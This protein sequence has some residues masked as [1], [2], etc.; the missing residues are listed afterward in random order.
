VCVTDEVARR[1]STYWACVRAVSEDVAKLPIVVARRLERGREILNGNR[2]HQLLNVQPNKYTTAI[3][4]RETMMAWVL[5]HGN[6]IA[7]IEWDGAGRPVALHVIP[8]PCVTP[9]IRK[10]DL[11]YDVQTPRGPVVTLEAD[12][13]FHL[14]GLG[15][16]SIWG[17]S[18]LKMARET[19]S[20]AT[21]ANRFA[22]SMF[23]KGVKASG[24]L[25]HPGKLSPTAAKNIRESFHERYAGTENAHKTI[26]LEEGMTWTPTSIT[27]EDAQMLETRQYDV[28][29]ICRWFRVAPHKVQHLA[30]ATY[31]NIEHQGQEYVGDSLHAWMTRWEQEG[32]IKLIGASSSTYMRHNASALVRGDYKSRMEGHNIARTGG[33]ASADDIR[34]LEDMNPLPDD[35]GQIY[36]VPAGVQSARAL[37]ATPAPDP[38]DPAAPVVPQPAADD[39]IDPAEERALVSLVSLALAPLLSVEVDKLSRSI[40]RGDVSAWSEKFHSDDRVARMLVPMSIAGEAVSAAIGAEPDLE[41]VRAWCS[42]SVRYAGAAA[43]S[44]DPAAVCA[45][46][47]KETRAAGLALSFIESVRAAARAKKEIGHAS[48]A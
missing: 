23:E 15:P 8:T 24:V 1:I 5:T 11:F 41:A 22:G 39:A 27:P 37:L 2:L 6:G 13:V 45:E 47:S 3:A 14:R 40:T 10:G 18:V 28:T 20:A 42:E 44:G 21:S 36:T 12:S 9:Y 25:S 38:V 43:R 30:D 29:E 26:V 7:E 48:E 32:Q 31:S 16:D 33:W 19:L 17:W 46:W 34:E 4:F 35:Q